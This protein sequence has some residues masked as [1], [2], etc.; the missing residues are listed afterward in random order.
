MYFPFSNTFNVTVNIQT[1]FNTHNACSNSTI[2]SEN[3]FSRHFQWTF[4]FYRNFVNHSRLSNR[5]VVFSRKRK[6][7]FFS[8][9]R[10]PVLSSKPKQHFKITFFL[11]SFSSTIR[12]RMME[13]TDTNRMTSFTKSTETFDS[14]NLSLCLSIIRSVKHNFRAWEEQNIWTTIFC[15][16]RKS[17]IPAESLMPHVRFIGTRK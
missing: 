1:H 16:K 15:L 7:H 13:R 6:Q 2:I 5:N 14:V 4:I 8:I 10:K 17:F 9:K 3:V 11:L 12:R